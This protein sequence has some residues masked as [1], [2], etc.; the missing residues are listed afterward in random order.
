MLPE[1]ALVKLGFLLGNRKPEEAKKMLGR[2]IA[3]E[4]TSRTE[5][6]W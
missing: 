4:I 2:D 5:V 3:G 1:V 6:E